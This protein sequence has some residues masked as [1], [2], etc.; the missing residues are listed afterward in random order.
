ML[1]SFTPWIL[2][3]LCMVLAVLYARARIALRSQSADLRKADATIRSI[4]Y[5]KNELISAVSHEIR[6]P[7]TCLLGYT[8]MMLE[9]EFPRER[10]VFYLGIISRETQRLN[11]L[12]FDF[13][14]VRFLEATENVKARP[15]RLE[16]LLVETFD[17][18]K[19][20]Q[21]G[22]RFV[23]DVADTLPAVKLDARRIRQVLSN[24]MSNAVKY[25]PDGGTIRLN[26]WVKKDR[27]VVCVQ[28]EGIGIPAEAIPKLFT[29]FFRVPGEHASE[30]PGTG[31]G[32]ALV[33]ECVRAHGGDTWVESGIGQGS[34]FYFSLPVDPA[35]VPTVDGWRPSSSRPATAR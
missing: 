2:G 21:G 31:L 17:L 27:V 13:L 29:K 12:L 20:Q 34:S 1:L 22:H 16:E 8:Q 5:S 30:I 28:D 3:A 11:S 14:E 26:A 19:N 7:L 35:D 10:Q 32:L 33:L 25:S 24:L 18:F 6:T 23:L 4:Q 9:N 15:E